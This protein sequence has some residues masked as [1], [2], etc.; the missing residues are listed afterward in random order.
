M[1]SSSPTALIAGQDHLLSSASS[2]A[3]IADAGDTLLG[4]NL[5][6]HSSELSSSELVQMWNSCPPSVSL[7]YSFLDL[8]QDDSPSQVR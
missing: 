2:M 1:F 7:S 8:A 4:Q 5:R 3:G 6:W